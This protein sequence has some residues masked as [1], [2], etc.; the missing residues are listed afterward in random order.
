MP[1]VTVLDRPSGAPSTTTPSPTSTEFDDPSDIGCGD[2]DVLTFRT[3]RSVCGSRPT[4]VAGAVAP[5]ENSTSTEPP[6][7]AIA[8]TWLFVM[9]WPSLSITSPVPVPPPP[10]P[11]AV[12]VTTDGR[13]SVA[14]DVT[15]H[16]LG[17]EPVSV[18]AAD[19]DGLLTAAMMPPTTPRNTRDAPT[20]A[21][22][23]HPRVSCARRFTGIVPSLSPGLLAGTRSG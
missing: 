20:T 2:C 11:L 6:L 15:L 8:M 18:L 21:H 23:S 17:D 3:A 9:M 19:V 13:T 22:G 5:S 12:I 4:M 10:A 14:I 1:D 7:A 16:V